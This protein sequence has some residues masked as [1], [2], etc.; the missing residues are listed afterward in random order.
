MNDPSK[1]SVTKRLMRIA[2]RLF[3]VVALV[4][5]VIANAK[6]A[7]QQRR[8][9]REL[10]PLRTEVA[11]LRSN[12]QRLDDLQVLARDKLQQERDEDYA[13]SDML[14]AVRSAADMPVNETRDFLGRG[15]DK[16]LSENGDEG[17]Y[18]VYFSVPTLG[19]HS[20]A[21]DV[22][23][24][25]KGEDPDYD[26]VPSGNR[27]TVPLKPGAA[28]EFRV[29]YFDNTDEGCQF[30]A[31]LYDHEGLLL[32]EKQF[33]SQTKY[34][35]AFSRKSNLGHFQSRLPT[36][37][38]LAHLKVP[39]KSSLVPEYGFEIRSWIYSQGCVDALSLLNTSRLAR[40]VIAAEDLRAEDPDS[41]RYLIPVTPPNVP[42]INE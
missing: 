37:T 34:D 36:V 13:I 11:E 23:P 17:E 4:L 16:W 25:V 38:E 15:V 5:L 14:K 9:E 22:I 6:S 7:F 2:V 35:S 40:A 3:F 33:S 19:S 31:R 28:Y 26:A 10:T 39:I 30:A 24:V 41:S 27:F 21:A 20:F 12:A 42:K 29:C 1:T 18:S 8:V 32:A